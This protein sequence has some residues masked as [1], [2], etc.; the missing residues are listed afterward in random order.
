M[1]MS[2]QLFSAFKFKNYPQLISELGTMGY[3]AVEGFFDLF[4][5]AKTIRV[6]LDKANM[7]MP[8][9]HMPLDMLENDLEKSL[10]ISRTLG[11]N[12][13]YAPWLEPDDRPTNSAGWLAL[14]KRLENVGKQVTDQG[15]GFGWHNHDFEFISLEDGR[16]GMEILLE[17]A[18][19]LEWEPDL[20]WIFRG[21]ADPL[22]WIEKYGKRIT[23]A[24]FKDVAPNWDQAQ[25][26]EWGKDENS[27][28]TRSTDDPAEYTGG[29][30]NPGTGILDW[31]SYFTALK[32][33][34]NIKVLA[35]EHDDT[36]DVL[37]FARQA[38][39]TYRSFQA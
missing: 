36:N 6:A 39:T 5:D 20:A 34:T 13:L 14:A 25:S 4:D 18:P 38:I 1:L 37:S 23:A 2:I 35:A 32:T 17:Y 24:H 27:I 16:T 9:I 7:S 22:P 28:D 10:T 31:K 12:T 21:G 29:W 33:Q 15:F 30:A 8:T 3:D 26:N 11:V 19:E